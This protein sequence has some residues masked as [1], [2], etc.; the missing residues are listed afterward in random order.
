[1]NSCEHSIEYSKAC[2]WCNR[3]GSSAAQ[4]ETAKKPFQLYQ[5]LMN[6]FIQ[7][8][9]HESHGPL[10][11]CFAVLDMNGQVYVGMAGHDD[12]IEDLISNCHAIL[13]QKKAGEDVTHTN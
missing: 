6:D 10:S 3:K 4:L 13:N 7:S 5:P 8:F 11:F 1:V 9:A 12:D 2:P